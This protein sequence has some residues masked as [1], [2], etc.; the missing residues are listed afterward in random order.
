M[1]G[2]IPDGASEGLVIRKADK[3][4]NSQNTIKKSTKVSMPNTRSFSQPSSRDRVTGWQQNPNPMPYRND[5][6]NSSNSANND[7]PFGAYD[8]ADPSGLPYPGG[9]PTFDT[10][11]FPPLIPTKGDVSPASQ[12]NLRHK[13]N[14]S[15]SD[16]PRGPTNFRDSNRVI[17]ESNKGEEIKPWNINAP[18]FFPTSASIR[19]TESN[20]SSLRNEININSSNPTQDVLRYESNL[21]HSNE[22]LMEF[23]KGGNVNL[24]TRAQQWN[25][26]ILAG[27]GTQSTAGAVAMHESIYDIRDPVYEA[28]KDCTHRTL[29]KTISSYYL[30]L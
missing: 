23:G 15:L 8:E 21:Y 10:N 9:F 27:T 11:E 26:R 3:K 7:F 22:N 6:W 5:S 12:S 1:N 25:D 16:F 24:E 28:G 14:E 29:V 30:I 2:K 18:E 4:R 17:D 19:Q 20:T 13:I